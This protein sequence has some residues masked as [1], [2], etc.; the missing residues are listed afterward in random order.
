MTL[1]SKLVA[2]IAGLLVALL[3]VEGSVVAFV[4]LP[5][6]QQIETDDA[7]AAM[8]RVEFGLQGAL[9]ELRVVAADWGDW[10]ETYEFMDD[11][12]VTYVSQYLNAQAMGHLHQTLLAIIDTRGNLV[13]SQ[14]FDPDS[15]GRLSVDLLAQPR[16]PAD[17]PWLDALR[18]NSAHGGLLA[19]NQGVMLAAVAPILDG[20]GKGPSRGLMLMARLLTERELAAL[21]SSVQVPVTIEAIRDPSGRIERPPPAL[22]VDGMVERTTITS[23]QI[24]LSRTYRDIYGN[25]VLTLRVQVSRAISAG[26][27]VAVLTMVAIIVAGTFGLLFILVLFLGR[28]TARIEA[29]K[30]EAEAAAAAKSDFVA[31]LSH[32]IRTPLNAIM[33][34][35]YLCQQAAPDARQQDYL[36]KIQAAAS[37]LMQI[38]NEV[39]DFSKLEANLVRLEDLRFSLVTVL[40]A[41]DL[42]VG[43]QA[44]RKGL[45][46]LIDTTPDVPVELRGD[47]LR[48]EQILMNLTGNALKFTAQGSIRLSVSCVATA[49][50]A[51]TLE[52]RVID[53][54]IGITPEQTGR[55]FEA[56]SQ[57]DSSTTRRFGGTGLGLAISKKLVQAMGGRIWFEPNPPGG[58]VFAFTVTLGRPPPQERIS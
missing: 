7:R 58:S 5:R 1:R 34:F 10:Q 48:L 4:L 55:L 17:F 35:A 41:V 51:S 6:F 15:G 16:L 40:T 33:G 2:A 24:Q 31:V 56:F 9:G 26:A 3:L 38:L 52:F 50:D 27:R 8:Q 45:E 20:H 29:G 11:R 44:R 43:E 22:Q 14:A 21:V 57:A 49:P 37:M 47:S 39:L 19:T 54:G 18:D 32:E 13:W 25:S 30:A 28:V 12:N 42:M 23:D 46:F 53:T 36:G